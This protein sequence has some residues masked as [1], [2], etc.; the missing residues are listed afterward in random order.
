[1]AKFNDNVKLPLTA[2]ERAQIIEVYGESAEEL[3]F[4][5]PNRLKSIKHILRN[6]VEVKLITDENLKK[7]CPKLSEMAESVGLDYSQEGD[8]NPKDFNPLKYGLNFYS[9]TAAM[10]HVDNT[11]YYIII[12]SQYQ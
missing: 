8:F 7:P 11:N 1:M 5:K 4:S 3:V 2:V 9:R 10:Y 6:R 12:K